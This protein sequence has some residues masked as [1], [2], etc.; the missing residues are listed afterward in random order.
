MRIVYIYHSLAIWGGIER[1]LIDKMNQLVRS[2][3]EDVCIVTYNQGQHEVPYQLDERVQHV[4]LNVRTN[5]VYAYGGLRRLYEEFRVAKL[6]RQRMIAAIRQLSPD[7]IVT[8][9]LEEV[10]FLFSA[11]LEIPIV[12]ESHNGYDGLYRIHSK[13]VWKLWRNHQYRRHLLKADAIVSM[14]ER[15]V[16]KWRSR[17]AK[18]HLIPNIVHLNPSGTVSTLQ[19]KRLIF[20]GR[21][22]EQKGIPELLDMWRMVVSR[23]PDWQLDIYGEGDKNYFADVPQGVNVCG[24]TNDIFAQYLHSSLLVLTSRWEPFGLVIPEAMSCGLPVVAFDEDGPHSIITD[25]EDGYLVKDRNVQEF[26]DRVCLLIEDETRRQQMG[27]KAVVSAQR[28]AAENIMP[29]WNKLFGSLAVQQSV[30]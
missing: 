2:N 18:I 29:L 24:V 5:A 6:L 15:D 10:D 19:E 22:D 27:R 23:H 7:V 3:D 26:A 4:D 28:Y 16:E 21:F 20:V 9:T 30:R 14:S 8:T 25:A 12:V 11:H 17:Y 1:V 13:N